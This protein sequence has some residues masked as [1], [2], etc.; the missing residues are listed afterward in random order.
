MHQGHPKPQYIIP[1]CRGRRRPDEAN[2]QP[3]HRLSLSLPLS[4][5]LFLPRSLECRSAINRGGELGESGFREGDPLTCRE[6]PDV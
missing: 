2:S 6:A 1:I 5:F 4:V 3:L